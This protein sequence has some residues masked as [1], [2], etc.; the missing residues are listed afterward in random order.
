M[1]FLVL[2]TPPSIYHV[3]KRPHKQYGRSCNE[4]TGVTS[5]SNTIKATSTMTSR[6]GHRTHANDST[7]GGSRHQIVGS[8]GCSNKGVSGGAAGIEG[9]GVGTTRRSPHR[10]G[11]NHLRVCCRKVTHHQGNTFSE[12]V[13]HHQRQCGFAPKRN[14]VSRRPRVILNNGVNPLAKTLVQVYNKES[15]R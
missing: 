2:V 13:F 3:D 10:D 6:G 12:Q 9:V 1:K 14:C 15:R 7:K 4:Y 8:G 11:S 5:T